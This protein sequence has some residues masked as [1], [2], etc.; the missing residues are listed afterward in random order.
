MLAAIVLASGMLYLEI[1]Y[2]RIKLE[3]RAMVA[4]RDI[5]ECD[6]RSVC[7]LMASGQVT[8]TAMKQPNLLDRI[9]QRYP[10]YSTV[11]ETT[12]EENLAFGDTEKLEHEMTVKFVL[13]M[14]P[15]S[16]CCVIFTIFP[17]VQT[18]LCWAK[19]CRYGIKED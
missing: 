8:S 4:R 2:M 11:H 15:L 5:I 7:S 17:L 12:I 14:Y 19:G 3:I 6:Y 9:L 1:R 18:I 13:K 16:V 10:H